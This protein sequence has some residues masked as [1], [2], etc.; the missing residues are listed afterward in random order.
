MSLKIFL[1]LS[2]WIC[3]QGRCST[4]TVYK[5]TYAECCTYTNI[6][7]NV[8]CLIKAI[9]W[10]K[11][12]AKI[13]MYLI[14]PLKNISIHFKLFKKDYANQYKPFLIDVRFNLCDIISKRNYLVYG[15]IVWK[16]MQRFTNVNHSCPLI[17]HLYA[18]NMYLDDIYLPSF[19][20]G[21]YKIL[22]NVNDVN[23]DQI[24]DHGSIALFFEAMEE[25]RSKTKKGQ[26]S[27]I[28]YMLSEE[29]KF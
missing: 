27:N 25:R 22:F 9:N 24:E 11:A 12:I 19:P 26:I 17:G 7:T 1:I 6:A 21:F 14:R 29:Q 2:L 15:T 8:T 10:S 3:W 18:R 20:L 16:T 13:D 28:Y 23:R 4:K 5:F